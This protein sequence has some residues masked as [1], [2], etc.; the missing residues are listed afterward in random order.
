MT[1]EQFMY[2]LDAYGASLH[3]WPPELRAAA[4]AFLASSPSA[5][6]A[7]SETARLD[8]VLD[9]YRVT[10]DL[11]SETRVRL[12]ATALAA[13]LPTRA[14]AD[15]A[16]GLWAAPVWQR[17]TALAF[18]ALLGVMTGVVQIERAPVEQSLFELSQGRG[19]DAPFEVAGL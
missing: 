3:R 2:Y 18:V 10:P 12:R 17:A 7:R 11:A 4:D 16:W 13:R 9:R 14:G 19:D 6:A 1:I 5:M 8:A 15:F